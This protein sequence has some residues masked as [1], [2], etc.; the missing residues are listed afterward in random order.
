MSGG[1]GAG[2]KAKYPFGIRITFP[3]CGARKSAGFTGYPLKVIFQSAVRFKR[4]YHISFKA[5][6]NCIGNIKNGRTSLRGITLYE[7]HG[8]IK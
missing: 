1:K 5:M 3:V 6:A 8:K 7:R 4:I 2:I